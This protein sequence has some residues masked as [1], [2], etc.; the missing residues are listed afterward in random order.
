MV[1]K[2]LVH[3]EGSRT[4][5]ALVGEMSGFQCHVVITRNMIEEFPLKDLKEEFPLRKSPKS[6]ESFVN[7]HLSTHRTTTGVLSVVGCFLHRA[8][9]KPM[10]AQKM[11]LETLISEKAILTFLAIQ[12]RS[13]VDHFRMDLLKETFRKALSYFKMKSHLDFMNPLHVITQLIQ[14]LNISIANL[15]DDELRLSTACIRTL[16]GLDPACCCCC[17]GN[18]V[19]EMLGVDPLVLFFDELDE[20]VNDER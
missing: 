12:R 14:I 4:D 17:R 16:S 10:R 6:I 19:I 7:P 13:I 2:Q 9:D 18:G 1:F 11:T 15:A 20:F 5:S 3:A 8:R